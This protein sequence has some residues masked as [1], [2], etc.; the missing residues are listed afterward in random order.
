MPS[1]F[2]LKMMTS[3]F[4]QFADHYSVYL[5]SRKSGQPDGYSTRD[6][7][8]DYATV[9]SN[10]LKGP[11]DVLGISYGGLIAQHFAADYPDLVRHLV[12]GVAA[13]RVSDEGKELDSLVSEL[14]SQGRWGKA[15][16][17]EMSGVYRRGFKKYLLHFLMLLFGIFRRSIPAHPSDFLI[18]AKAEVNHDSKQRLAEIKVP[19]LVI[20]G[21]QDFFFPAELYRETAAGIPNAKL[22]LYKELGHNAFNSKRF[23]K[24]VLAFLVS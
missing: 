5:M 8:D 21:D 20:G 3:S 2:M 17:A 6:M 18:E 11:V 10:E 22:I 9:I 15:Y 16:A 4:K 12:I 24:D 19:T 14:Q 1:G 7:S 13:Y 23:V